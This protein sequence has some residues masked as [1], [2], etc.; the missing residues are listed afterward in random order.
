MSDH[1]SFPVIKKEAFQIIRKTLSFQESKAKKESQSC[2]DKPLKYY[3]IRE[4][5]DRKIKFMPRTITSRSTN[6]LC[7]VAITINSLL[8]SK[9]SLHCSNS[10]FIRF[11]GPQIDIN[12]EIVYL[13]RNKLSMIIVNN[14]FELSIF[15]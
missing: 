1:P 5:I 2:K 12:Y 4:N 10:K 13:I 11:I 6:H 9:L 15:R 7:P 8:I 14:Q 3:L